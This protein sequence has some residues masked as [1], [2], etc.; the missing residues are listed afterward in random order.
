VK[1]QLGAND[2][3]QLRREH[4]PIVDQYLRPI[5]RDYGQEAGVFAI[6][7]NV[8]WQVLGGASATA[9][10]PQTAEKLRQILDRLDADDFR[11]R[12]KAAAD[13][14][15]MGKTASLALEKMDRS[16]LSLQQSSAVDAFLAEAAPLQAEDSSD[17]AGDKSFLLDVLFSDEAELRKMAL[18]RLSDLSG[19]QIALD[20]NLSPAAR[21]QAVAR[22]RA[23]VIPTTQPAS[24]D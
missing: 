19:K 6:P 8:A 18:K 7:S 21:A 9:T 10:D 5:L 2:F 16:K 1:I 11:E 12:Q 23:E 14:K 24:S 22:L 17:L 4:Q 3:V 20:P 15:A 13:L